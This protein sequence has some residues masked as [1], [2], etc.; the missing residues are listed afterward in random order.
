MVAKIAGQD[1]KANKEN[2]PTAASTVT[3]AEK[4]GQLEM[5]V[6]APSEEKTDTNVF[7]S[8]V[9]VVILKISFNFT[10]PQDY[11][12]FYLF[13]L[14]NG[15]FPCGDVNAESGKIQSFNYPN[16]YPNYDDCIWKITVPS[17][18]IVTLEFETPFDVR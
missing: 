13:P 18:S 12:F 9:V 11:N 14:A 5:D 17:G 7:W 8:Q 15:P 16:D 3:A 10:Q 1:V 4:D 6:T 2:V